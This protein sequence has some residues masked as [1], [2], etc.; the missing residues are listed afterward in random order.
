MQFFT[1]MRVGTKL[2][3]GFLIVAF[4]GAVVGA[5]GVYALSQ[6][7]QTA[8][9]MYR[10][11][12]LGIQHAGE[13]KSQIEAINTELRS[14]FTASTE[15]DRQRAVNKIEELFSALDKSL[16][17]ARLSFS[18]D[19]GRAYL[20]GISFLAEDYRKNINAVVARLNEQPY[21]VQTPIVQLIRTMAVPLANELSKATKQAIEQKAGVARDY[22]RDIASRFITVRNGLIIMVAIS[23]LLAL[24]LGFLIT[25]VLIRQLGGEPA[26]VSLVADAVSHGNLHNHI[27]LSRAEPGSIMYSMHDM[28]NALRQTVLEVR[29]SSDSIAAGSS[30]I[31]A[32]NMDLSQRTEEQA[33]NVTQTASAMEEIT[34]TLRSNADSAK[35]ATQLAAVVRS[36]AVA[37]QNAAKDV[38]ASMED[39]RSSSEQIVNI[40]NVIDSIA[41]QTNILAL[42]AAVES[43]RAGEAGR[44]FAVV[45]SEVRTLAQRSASAA[46]DIKHLIEDSVSKVSEGNEKAR[47]AGSTIQSMVEQVNQVAT[48]ID[49][50][51]AA[52]LE[53]SMGVEQVNQAIGQ[54]EEVT[55]QNSALV[56]QSAVAAATLNDQAFHLVDVMRIFDLGDAIDVQARERSERTPAAQQFSSVDRQLLSGA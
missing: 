23:T 10:Y 43:A 40:I 36:S 6:V 24:V 31:S 20:E 54:L 38:E 41:F 27:D 46:Q 16:A 26:E 30:Q 13:A 35:E 47:L 11:E 33:A 48:L 50:I 32:G 37:G 2:I 53:Q 3:A 9:N 12:T 49:E 5:V 29:H 44:G 28:Q 1:N 39:M 18:T 22:N 21:F 42:N 8:D 4:L 34:S 17:S 55:Q 19:E 15:R 14:I 56:E 51:S 7:N 52:T 45:A 25:R